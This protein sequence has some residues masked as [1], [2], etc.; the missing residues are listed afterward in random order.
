M[1]KLAREA[2]EL[3]YETVSE[4]IDGRAMMFAAAITFYAVMSL[5]P[6]LLIVT[7][8][9]GSIFGR[10]AARMRVVEIVRNQAGES[11]AH[12]VRD[13]A[14]HLGGQETGLLPTIIGTLFLLL[15]STRLFM[16]LQEAVN[17]TWQVPHPVEESWFNAAL[18]HISRRVLSFF[19]VVALG[20]GV[21][22]LLFMSTAWG[23]LAARFHLDLPGVAGMGLVTRHA[24][25]FLL[26]MF[27]CSTVFRVLPDANIAWR[28]VW[29][30]AAGTTLLILAS[31]WLI[32]E[33]F[34]Y[35]NVGTIYGAAGALFVLLL[36]LYYLAIVFF[37]G[38][39][40]THVFARRHGYGITPKPRN[41][42]MTPLPISFQ[43]LKSAAAIM[44]PVS[45]MRAL[46]KKTPPPPATDPV[47]SAAVAAEVSESSGSATPRVSPAL[48]GDETNVTPRPA[49]PIEA[50]SEGSDETPASPAAREARE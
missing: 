31:E 30:G 50:V 12:V 7:G 29:V 32:A 46:K 3:L 5:S 22:A 11:N 27:V 44:T 17:D 37:L 14:E 16:A 23:A 40:F 24:S 13:V 48:P 41:A 4:F 45:P 33:Y 10:E 25:N 26:T 19:L 36:W 21:G 1:R 9:A 2:Y 20:I 43:T 18:H 42:T 47:P 35:G 6:T 39:H 8:V 28:D 15:G 34:S 49:S 38:V